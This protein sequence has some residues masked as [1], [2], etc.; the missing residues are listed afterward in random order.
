MT[1]LDKIP[2]MTLTHLR[3]VSETASSFIA[4]SSMKNVGQNTAIE[5]FHDVSSRQLWTLFGGH[6][7]MSGF[8]PEMWSTQRLI[9]ALAHDPFIL[10]TDCSVYALTALDLDIHHLLRLC[11]LLEIVKVSHFMAP[12]TSKNY[13]VAQRVPELV[14]LIQH[15]P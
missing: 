1:L 14:M 7:Q 11:Y 2:A 6:P 10:L 13:F 8:G 5:E 12:F 3:I 15:L 4:M 9:P